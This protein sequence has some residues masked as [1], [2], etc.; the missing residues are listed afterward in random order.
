[1]S[2]IDPK[3][4]AAAWAAFR[5]T[6]SSDD[7][8]DPMAKALRAYEAHKA[9]GFNWQTAFHKTHADMCS[10]EADNYLLRKQLEQ[11]GGG[12]K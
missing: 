9:E 3:G 6:H 5:G 1:M 11:L 4:L 8:L 7:E 2:Y 12:S 10:L